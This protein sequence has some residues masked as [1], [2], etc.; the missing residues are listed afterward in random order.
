VTVDLVTYVEFG[1][2]RLADFLPD[3]A[4]I[5]ALADWEYMD[6]LWI[7]EGFGFSEFLRL[8]DDPEVVRSIA[9]DLT[10]L[11]HEV[12]TAILDTLRLPLAPGMHIDEVRMRLG[13]PRK[14]EHFVDD[15]TSYSFTCGGRDRYE[16]SCTFGETAGLIYVSVLAP[17]PRRLVA[18]DRAGEP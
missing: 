1:R 14:A 6:D 11:P 18:S 13:Q 16:I 8:E 7:G 2:L 5:E 17:T 9:L 15:R 3:P 12:T 10:A 4:A